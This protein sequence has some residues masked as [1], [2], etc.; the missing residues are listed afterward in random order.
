MTPP[1]DPPVPPGHPF[2]RPPL[3]FSVGRLRS[4]L[5]DSPLNPYRA[6]PSSHQPGTLGS[7]F[8]RYGHAWFDDPFERLVRERARAQIWARE[9]AAVS[10]KPVFWEAGLGEGEVGGE[11]EKKQESLVRPVAGAL[12]PLLPL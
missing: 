2:A 1:A 7:S 12:L 11:K 6:G 9:V 3:Q 5:A 10:A 4:R 8:D